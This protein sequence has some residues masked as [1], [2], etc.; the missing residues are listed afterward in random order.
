MPRRHRFI[1]KALKTL[2]LIYDNSKAEH[3]LNTVE[4]LNFLILN[5]RSEKENIENEIRTCEEL[6]EQCKDLVK[7]QDKDLNDL[8]V[9]KDQ[10]EIEEYQ[11][12][13]PGKKIFKL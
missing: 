11:E 1:K 9:L 5:A 13:N 10:I 8:K 4:D 7:T 6:I 2:G 3:P 12:L